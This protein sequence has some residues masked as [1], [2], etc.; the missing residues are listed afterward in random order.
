MELKI[1]LLNREKK[2]LLRVV[3]GIF[4]ITG[5]FLWIIFRK[6]IIKPYDWAF[7]GIFVLNGVFHLIEGLGYAAESVFGKSFIVINSELISLKSGVFDKKQSIEWVEIKSV[8]CK[9]NTYVFTKTDET[10][11]TIR[12]SSFNYPLTKEIEKAIN[13]IANEKVIGNAA[14]CAEA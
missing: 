9:W 1:D 3:F 6:E 13:S 4:F 12:T 5:A 10:T 7:F 14:K 11:K 2:S 8:Y